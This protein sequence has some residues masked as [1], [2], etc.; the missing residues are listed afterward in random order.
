MKRF[1]GIGLLIL[2][3]GGILFAQRTQAPSPDESKILALESAWNLAEEEKNTNALDQMLAA[4]FVYTEYD[5]SFSNKSQFLK[6]I[7]T[8]PVNSDQITNQDVS[9]TVYANSAIVTGIYK[10]KGLANGKQFTRRGRYTDSWVNQGGVWLCVASQ[11]TL[12]AH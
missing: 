2:L 1:A 4:T 11:A 10:E 8:S 5:G 9:V 7:K 3:A 6:A 12:I